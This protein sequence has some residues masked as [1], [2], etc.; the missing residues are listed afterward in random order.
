[1]ILPTSLNWLARKPGGS[2]WLQDLPQLIA[3]ALAQWN[4]RPSGPPYTGGSVSYVAPVARGDERFV[5]KIQWPHDE[6]E[7]EADALREWRGG[8][9]VR[10]VAHDPMKNV[11]LL[12]ECIPGS[13]LADSNE[14]DPIA[15]V[16]DLLPRLWIAT[17]FAFRTLAEE[18]AQWARNL[19][20]HWEKVGKPCERHL[21]DEALRYIDLLSATQGQQVLLHQDLHGHNILIVPAG[22]VVGD[23][24]ETALWRTGI[25]PRAHR[26]KLRI[27]SLGARHPRP[28][29]APVSSLW[30]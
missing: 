23:R 20:G 18:A 14:A 11:L 26:Q 3:D 7:H 13:F 9:A 27:W 29:G 17:D 16:S 4:L 30:P 22:T 5:L 15:V 10:L 6:A 2:K 28:V 8:G 1:M 25:F 24:P 19:P 12:E 21:I